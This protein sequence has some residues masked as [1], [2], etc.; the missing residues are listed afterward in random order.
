MP[1]CKDKLPENDPFSPNNRVSL[2]PDHTGWLS[3]ENTHTH[4]HAHTHTH[5]HTH[6]PHAAIKPVGQEISLG[7]L[8]VEK[9]SRCLLVYIESEFLSAKLVPF[10]AFVRRAFVWDL[11]SGELLLAKLLPTAQ[12]RASSCAVNLPDCVRPTSPCSGLPAV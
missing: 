5:T 10:E 2:P 4:T 11:T 3:P 12:N 8:L 6:T 1:Y 7:V 9:I